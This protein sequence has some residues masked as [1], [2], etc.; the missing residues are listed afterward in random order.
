VDAKSSIELTVSTF[1]EKKNSISLESKLFLDF[2]R[3]PPGFV[4]KEVK[5]VVMDFK[6]NRAMSYGKRKPGEKLGIITEVRGE[7]EIKIYIGD[8]LVK[9]QRVE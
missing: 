5:V 1:Y 6:G 8:K 9:I 2:I 3:I 4:E 7:G